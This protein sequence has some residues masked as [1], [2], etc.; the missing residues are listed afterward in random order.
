MP[1]I[2]K[3]KTTW[4]KYFQYVSQFKTS[5]KYY[6]KKNDPDDRE[7]AYKLVKEFKYKTMKERREHFDRVKKAR[8]RQEIKLFEEGKLK[9]D[10]DIV[11]DFKEYYLEKMS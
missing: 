10:P 3:N 11:I 9:L 4:I 6:F 8:D 2:I 1:I 7:K 5:E